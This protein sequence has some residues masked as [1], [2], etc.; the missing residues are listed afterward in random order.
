MHLHVLSFFFFFFKVCCWIE[1]K[2]K[3]PYVRE[4]MEQKRETKKV[5]DM[6]KRLTC[7]EEE[8]KK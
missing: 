4:Q 6:M 1:R 3:V 2:N 8:G 7:K 5:G